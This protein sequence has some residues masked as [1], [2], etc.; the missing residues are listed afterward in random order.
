M[1]SIR[2]FFQKAWDIQFLGVTEDKKWV[3]LTPMKAN[4]TFVE[5]SLLRYLHEHDL[6]H[7]IDNVWQSQLMPLWALVRPKAGGFEPCFVVKT[8]ENRILTWPAELVELKLWRP[9]L[10]VESLDTRVV[11]DIDDRMACPMSAV[12]PL[13][14]WLEAYA[15]EC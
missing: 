2:S 11:F 8:F 15:Y 12:C 7:R 10:D 3:G 14:G 1:F 5:V 13:I 9:K 6:W 4:Q